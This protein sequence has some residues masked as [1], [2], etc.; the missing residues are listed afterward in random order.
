MAVEDA[1]YQQAAARYE[2]TVLAALEDVENALVRHDREQQRRTH[3]TEA[4]R[5]ARR[6]VELANELYLRGL[7]DF[8]SVLEAQRAL[9][10]VED[11]LAASGQAV[12]VNLVA[13]FKALGGGW[14]QTI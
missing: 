1:R 11:E 4:G 12:V 7:S 6:A 3:L 9:Y 5:A 2:S 10:A 13:L 14:Q 8:L